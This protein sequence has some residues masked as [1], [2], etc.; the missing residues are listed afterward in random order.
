MCLAR[1]ALRIFKTCQL[2]FCSLVKSEVVGTQYG[3]KL[4]D[5]ICITY[6]F[7]QGKEVEDI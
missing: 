4:I 5:H 3:L 7:L 6:I 2:A 1:L